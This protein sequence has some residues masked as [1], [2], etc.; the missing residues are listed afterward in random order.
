M[1]II[2]GIIPIIP[3]MI[4]II[5]GMMAIIPGI[6][7][8]ILGMIAIIPGMMA[9]VLGI[10]AIVL[11]M[12][13]IIPG[14]MAIVLGIIAIIPRTIAIIPRIIPTI[15]GP[16][17]SRIRVS[18]RIY[19]P[20]LIFHISH[21]IYHVSFLTLPAVW[22]TPVST[23]SIITATEWKQPPFLLFFGS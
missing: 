10:I 4:R 19:G 6:I 8:I 23:L 5:L 1:A 21:L 15:H 17:N 11:G 22:E 20:I 16:P 3:R 13:A 2:H 12:I 7:A 9:I 14:M 18:A